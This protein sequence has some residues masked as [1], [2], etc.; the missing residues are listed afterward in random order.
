MKG[1]RT[2]GHTEPSGDKGSTPSKEKLRSRH[3]GNALKVTFR[4]QRSARERYSEQ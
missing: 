2:A 3:M 1:M 4:Y